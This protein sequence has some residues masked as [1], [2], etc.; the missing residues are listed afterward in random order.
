[1]EYQTRNEMGELRFFATFQRA[2]EAYRA[3]RTIFKISWHQNRWTLKTKAEAWVPYLE[4]KLEKIS[5]KY[6][7]EKERDKAYW[8]HQSIRPTRM[9]RSYYTDTSV[10]DEEQQKAWD[11]DCIQEILSEEEFTRRFI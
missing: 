10:P 7:Q 8:V 11:L 3:D 4:N 1:M 6:A 5:E 2:F 9:P